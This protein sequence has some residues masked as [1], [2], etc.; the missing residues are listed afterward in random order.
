MGI[1]NYYILK[2]QLYLL[3]L[4]NNLY[5]I[6]IILILLSS[7]IKSKLYKLYFQKFKIPFF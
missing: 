2:Y 1:N 3:F 5:L 7:I 6:Q 4:F